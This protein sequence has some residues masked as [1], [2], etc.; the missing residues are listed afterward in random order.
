MYV[1]DG[2]KFSANMEK[3]FNLFERDKDDNLVNAKMSG[4]G[5]KGKEMFYSLPL[6]P[7][8]T[9]II[10][11]GIKDEGGNKLYFDSLIFT[12]TNNGLELSEAWDI[13]S[14]MPGKGNKEYVEYDGTAGDMTGQTGAG[15]LMTVTQTMSNTVEA[16]AKYTEQ[17]PVQVPVYERQSY[18]NRTISQ[19]HR[20]RTYAGCYI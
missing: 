8:N 12:Y 6:C 18:Y 17:G 4:H 14:F 10:N 5:D 15:A 13:A 9:A 19:V 1:W 2:K 7:A 20:R 3:N 11:K 16:T